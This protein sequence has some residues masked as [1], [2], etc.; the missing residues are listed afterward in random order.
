MMN[1]DE[2]PEALMQQ[3]YAAQMEMFR[4]ECERVFG[5]L[6]DFVKDEEFKGDIVFAA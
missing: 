4:A 6:A 3:L 5:P 2:S 1:G